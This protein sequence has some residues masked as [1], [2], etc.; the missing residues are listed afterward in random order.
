M[1]LVHAVGLLSFD[2][3][4][5]ADGN[6]DWPDL[7]FDSRVEI[8]LGRRNE[9]PKRGHPAKCSSQ[10][11][12]RRDKFEVSLEGALPCVALGNQS[13]QTGTIRFLP[14]GLKFGWGGEMKMKNPKR[15]HPARCVCC[16]PRRAGRGGQS[17]AYEA[18]G[19]A[20]GDVDMPDVH[21]VSNFI[22]QPSKFCWVTKFI[23]TRVISSSS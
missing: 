13:F 19:M 11:S 17:C 2:S 5:I 8:W 20:H 6:S 10:N 14:A 3:F 12:S 4:L 7:V 9:N 16:E 18:P 22:V 23:C 1:D 15:G 21:D